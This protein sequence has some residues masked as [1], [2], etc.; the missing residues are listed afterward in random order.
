[1]A[2]SAAVRIK[3][4]CLCLGGQELVA[5]RDSPFSPVLGPDL[6]RRRWRDGSEAL[7]TDKVTDA[8]ADIKAARG[9]DTAAMTH[10]TF[11]KLCVI[12]LEWWWLLRCRALCEDHLR[13]APVPCSEGSGAN[14]PP[15]P[16]LPLLFSKQEFQPTA[17]TR[18]VENCTSHRF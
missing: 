13:D 5:A 18:R 14:A 10:S 17:E 9:G 8:A 11:R 3:C 16:A 2:G 12:Y 6:W 15:T 1:M 4:V 7:G